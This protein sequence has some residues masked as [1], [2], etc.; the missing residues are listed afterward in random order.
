MKIHNCLVLSSMESLNW[1][2]NDLLLFLI[3][4]NSVSIIEVVLAA[5]YRSSNLINGIIFFEA[6]IG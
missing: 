1:L 3:L 6:I 2:L 4:F 5:F